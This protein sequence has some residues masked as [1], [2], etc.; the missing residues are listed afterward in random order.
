[1]LELLTGQHKTKELQ[2]IYNSIPDLRNKPTDLL[3]WL[4]TNQQLI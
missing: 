4:K 3:K 2:T 1:M